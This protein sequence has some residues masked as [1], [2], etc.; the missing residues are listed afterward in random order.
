MH[1]VYVNQ[2]ALARRETGDISLDSSIAAQTY[3]ARKIRVDL[4]VQ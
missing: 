4:V 3:I 2:Y 1:N